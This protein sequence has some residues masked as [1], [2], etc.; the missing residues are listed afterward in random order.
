MTPEK[1]I[2]LRHFANMNLKGVEA[3][4]QDGSMHYQLYLEIIYRRQHIQIKSMIN[5]PVTENLANLDMEL[6]KRMQTEEELV[7][8]IIRFEESQWK[9][10]HLIRGMGKRYTN[11][12]AAIFDIVDD[13]L[14]VK[15]KKAILRHIR[16][17]IDVLNFENPVIPVER[18][19]NAA[20][21]LWP[22]L[23]RYLDLESY[24]QEI[25]LWQKY[26]LIFPR[27]EK[28]KIKYPAF[29]DWLA[30]DHYNRVRE[31]LLNENRIDKN[32]IN[33]NLSEVNR[34]VRLATIDQ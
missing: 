14:R 3:E 19:F 32:V 16:E 25:E 20:K 5:E 10:K 17:H 18:I 9:D 11:Y 31:K 30:E 4:T 22:D 6:Y 27:T 12:R 8:K 34:I 28:Y 2:T 15:L 1:K 13:G 24:R 33:N 7:R 26:F 21:E 23:D 29:I